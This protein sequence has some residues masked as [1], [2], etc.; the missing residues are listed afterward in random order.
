MAQGIAILG[1][2]AIGS[3]AAA[4]IF[5]K[6]QPEPAVELAPV[7]K[8]TPM[9]APS[10]PP[11]VGPLPV[12]PGPLPDGLANL[13]AQA[14]N[15]CHYAAHDGW[16]DSAHAT[17]AQSEAF[18]EVVAA[19]GSPACTTCHLPL[20][21][22]HARV[23]TFDDGDIHRPVT[24]PRPDWDAGLAAEGV[25]CA[26]CH[27]RDGQVLGA[28][29]RPVDA[30]VAAHP[31][32]WSPV[33]R[34]SEL[35]ATCHQMTWP[36]ADRP[37]YDTYG[38]WTR[39]AYADAGVQCQD[40]HMGA[41]AAGERLG[42]DHSFRAAEGRAVSVLLDLPTDLL[43]RGDEPVAARLRLQNSGA[44]HAWPTGSP[45][46]GVRLLVTLEG[47]ED[48]SVSVLQA[49][50]ARVLEEAPPWST[51]AD[52]RLAPGEER[53]FDLSLA[54]DHDLPAGDWQLR[55]ALAS[56]VR[57]ALQEPARTARAVPLRVE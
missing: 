50:L 12:D 54:L 57:G 1:L 10:E 56:V 51:T 47:P 28:Q 7:V 8:A 23:W 17:G 46:R 22:Q 14:C 55:I 31:V 27:V 45:F 36:G 48:A 26:A 9:Q 13:G 39:S 37:F 42:S 5:G 38:E 44:G 3:P 11:F 52:T 25:T 30:A 18:R 4:G 2:L 33:L 34:Q 32:G 24:A 16:S 35:C 15:A 49:D 6:R 21:S 53:G 40:C 29:P 19:V 43:V 20:A 41:G